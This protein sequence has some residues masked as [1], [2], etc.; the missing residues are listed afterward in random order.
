M[1]IGATL[2]NMC[3]F[4]KTFTKEKNFIISPVVE[5]YLWGKFFIKL[6]LC[7]KVP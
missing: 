7:L 1:N 4:S 2:M 3:V 5:G 6:I